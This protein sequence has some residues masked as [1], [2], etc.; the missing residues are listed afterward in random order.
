MTLFGHTKQFRHAL[1]ANWSRLYRTAFAWTHE[2]FLAHDLVQETMSRALQH[3][4]KITDPHALEIWLFKVMANYWR[5]LQRRRRNHTDVQDI[6]LV[7]D[8]TPDADVDRTRLVGQVRRAINQLNQHQRQ[9]IT[10]I[11]IEGFS[12]DEVARI[13]EI[14]VGTVMSRLCR[15]RQ[16]LKQQL[17]ATADSI[18]G[19]DRVRRLK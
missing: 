5:D 8:N 19:A 1:E 4:E 16:N 7:D 11:A 15:A 10:L 17:N 9:V 3:K 6:E 2:R 18:P 13:L 12:Y 14:P